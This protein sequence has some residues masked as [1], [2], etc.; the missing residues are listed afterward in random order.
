MC[1]YTLLSLINRIKSFGQILFA[2]NCENAGDFPLVSMTKTPVQWLEK[3]PSAVNLLEEGNGRN[4]GVSRWGKG[5]T[6]LNK[7]AGW[8]G[9]G[10]NAKS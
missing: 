4:R 3:S 9:S 2:R 8:G 7:E 1:Q 10:R 6:R 5:R